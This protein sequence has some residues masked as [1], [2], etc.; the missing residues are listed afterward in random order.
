MAPLRASFATSYDLTVGVKVDMDEA[1][2]LMSP[3]DSPF[4]TGVDSD[5]MSVL[6]SLPTNERKVEWMHDAILAPRTIIGGALTTA[7]TAIVLPAGDGFKFS[8]GDLLLLDNETVRIDSVPTSIALT[9]TRAVAGTAVDHASGTVGV[10]VGQMLAEGSDPPLPRFTDRSPFYNV[11]QIFGPEAVSMSATEQVVGKYGVPNEMSHQLFQRTQELTQRRE[12]AIA[13]GQ[14]VEDD[15][16]TRRAMRG[17]FYS[18]TSN[19]TSTAVLNVTS[20]AALQQTAWNAGG[21]PDRLAANPISLTDLN[22]IADSSRVRQDFVDTK[23]GRAPVT[24]VVSEFG[25][26]AIVRNRYLRTTDAFLFSR[27]QVVRRPLRPLVLERLAKTGDRDTMMIVCEESL[28]IKGQGHMA[29]FTG[30]TYS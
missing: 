25:E 15:A 2:Y 1:I 11:T 7:T 20:L 24:T 4:L 17:I 5:G 19:T 14:L 6:S 22:A 18:I 9:V 30:L 26:I 28:E 29:K 8:V 3:L 12:Q 16:G 10:G 21:Q 23:R 27:D 13:Y